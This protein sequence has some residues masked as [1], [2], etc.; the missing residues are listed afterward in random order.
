VVAEP[1][2]C[3]V[4]ACKGTGET[5][6]IHEKQVSVPSG[7]KPPKPKNTC[8]LLC[9]PHS[10]NYP[11]LVYPRFLFPSAARAC[12][13]DHPRFRGLRHPRC[14]LRLSPLLSPP[15]PSS[16]PDLIGPSTS[17]FLANEYHA[18]RLYLTISVSGARTGKDVTPRAK[19]TAG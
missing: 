11:A 2:A 12:S 16:W 6:L 9:G 17:C 14:G 5:G 19:Q 8:P 3:I 15:P 10:V 18:V 4:V 1:D 7:L 13:R